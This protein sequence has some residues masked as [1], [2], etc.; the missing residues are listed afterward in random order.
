LIASQI[1]LDHG[2][3][4][5]LTNN[6]NLSLFQINL[7][8]SLSHVLHPGVIL[9]YDKLVT[10]LARISYSMNQRPLG[11]AN[12]SQNSLQEDQLMPL[13]SNMM[14]LGKNSNESPPLDYAEDQKFT[15]RLGYVAAVE[16]EWWKKR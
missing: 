15:A 5:Y 12:T 10:L 6:L 4:D 1:I 9:N 7:P 8:K 11:L 16:T 2:Y 14:L 3:F 13:T